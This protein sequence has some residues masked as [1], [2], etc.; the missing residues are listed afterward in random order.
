MDQRKIIV[1]IA[2]SADGYIARADGSFDWLNRPR[3][4][5]DYGMRE[6]FRSIDTIIWGRNTY[7]ISL[8]FSKK[9]KGGNFGANIKSYVFTHNPPPTKPGPVEFVNEPVNDFASRL[10]KSPGKNIWMM[11]GA[12]V[13]G[14]FL[15][16]G[17]LDEFIIH[18]IPIFIGEGIPL[19]AA[20]HRN[21]PLKLLSTHAYPD[22]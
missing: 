10:R 13:I 19:I 9:G 22:G 18:V 12:G 14:S 1:H 7:D 8:R 21:V 16:A 11:G 6:F 17:E 4:A 3:T 2:T 20:R 15:D 5:G